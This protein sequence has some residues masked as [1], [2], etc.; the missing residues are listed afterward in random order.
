IR[1]YACDAGTPPEQQPFAAFTSRANN[2]SIKRRRSANRGAA[3]DGAHSIH[4]T[5]ES[6]ATIESVLQENRVFPPR[7]EFVKQ[8]NVSGMDGYRKLCAEAERDFEGFWARLAREEVL[9]HKPFTKF[10]NDSKA[11]FFK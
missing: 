11:P 8:A 5:E 7:P 10:L 9:W 3:R 2:A 6:M 4:V 1:K